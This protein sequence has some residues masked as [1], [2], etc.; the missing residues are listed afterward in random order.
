MTLTPL[1]YHAPLKCAI[2]GNPYLHST[3][4]GQ[5]YTTPQTTTLLCFWIARL[6]FLGSNDQIQS[7]VRRCS[8]ILAHTFTALFRQVLRERCPC[9]TSRQKLSKEQAPA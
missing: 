4:T 3:P 8:N 2:E 7:V 6:N 1:V 5:Y 9:S